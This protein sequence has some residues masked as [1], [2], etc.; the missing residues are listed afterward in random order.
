MTSWGW[1]CL[2]LVGVTT[3]G[4]VMDILDDLPGTMLPARSPRTPRPYSE[5][6]LSHKFRLA[7]A[8]AGLVTPTPTSGLDYGESRRLIVTSNG[9]NARALVAVIVERP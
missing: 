1:L 6:P 2:V 9:G 8:D 3:A 4:H 5:S 7:A